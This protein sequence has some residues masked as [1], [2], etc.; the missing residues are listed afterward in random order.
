MLDVGMCFF[1]SGDGGSRNGMGVY[2]IYFFIG[3]FLSFVIG[4]FIKF[5]FKRIG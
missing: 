3:F 2:G 5:L 1:S 4:F